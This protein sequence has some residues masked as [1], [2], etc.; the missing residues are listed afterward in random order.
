[1]TFLFFPSDIISGG[2]EYQVHQKHT[3][4]FYHEDSEEMYVGGTDFVLQLD[5]DDYHIIEVG[6]SGLTHFE[7]LF[8]ILLFCL[9]YHLANALACILFINVSNG[10]LMGFPAR[11][12]LSSCG[13]QWSL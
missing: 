2:F 1:M 4:F 11:S 13:W 10:L 8:L 7:P 5:V 9:L 12:L 6:V 3:V